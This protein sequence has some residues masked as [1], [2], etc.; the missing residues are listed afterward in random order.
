M[1]SV[2][3]AGTADL[4]ASRSLLKVLRTDSGTLATYSSTSFGAA[5]LFAV[6][7][8]LPDFTLFMGQCYS[9]CHFKSMLG[10]TAAHSVNFTGRPSAVNASNAFFR[11]KEAHGSMLG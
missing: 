2:A 10:R 4:I 5:L 3:S 1:V 7:L 9:H 11:E 8:R 6:E